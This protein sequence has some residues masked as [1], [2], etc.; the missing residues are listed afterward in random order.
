VSDH[1]HFLPEV[2]QF[3]ATALSWFCSHAISGHRHFEQRF[4]II[5]AGNN[6]TSCD[7]NALALQSGNAM[8]DDGEYRRVTAQ[9]LMNVARTCRRGL[10]RCL[11][12]TKESPASG[13]QTLT[14]YG[15]IG[16]QLTG[17]PVESAASPR[18]RYQ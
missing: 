14:P 4:V 17:V 16:S 12:S 2:R 6:L 7:E 11:P 13:K 1:C 18:E 8:L 15:T 5:V 9:P 10:Q 3:L